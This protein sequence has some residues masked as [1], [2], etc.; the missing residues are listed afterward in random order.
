MSAPPDQRTPLTQAAQHAQYRRW[1]DVESHAERLG[2]PYA[3]V[4]RS[5][6]IDLLNFIKQRTAAAQNAQ[7]A[8]MGE[9]WTPGQMPCAPLPPVFENQE[10]EK[11]RVFETVTAASDDMNPEEVMQLQMML[12]NGGDERMQRAVREQRKETEH[13]VDVGAVGD[14][15][16]PRVS[17]ADYARRIDGAKAL[18]EVVMR[19]IHKAEE[20]E[21]QIR[22]QRRIL[23]EADDIFDDNDKA[24]VLQSIDR[25][26]KKMATI[27]MWLQRLVTEME[28]WAQR[29]V[30]Y[31]QELSSVGTGEEQCRRIVAKVPAIEA[32]CASY[33]ARVEV[34]NR[35]NK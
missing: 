10:D 31:A 27:S 29:Q 1:P 3:H 18:N 28:S 13:I 21:E 30:R 20:Y 32:M 11:R 33:K 5:R 24:G 34:I 25:T 17:V 15:Q 16:M 23:R 12:L 35:L 19:I 6:R 7:N 22:Q 9:R 4:I 14:F 8:G 2:M 26:E